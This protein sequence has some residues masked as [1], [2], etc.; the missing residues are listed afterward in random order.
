MACKFEFDASHGIV[1]CRFEGRLTDE[2]MKDYY[3]E[4]TEVYDTTPGINSALTDFSEVTSFEVSGQTILELASQEPALR[5]PQKIR[6][7][8][9]P[10]PVI[11][12]MARMFEILGERTRPNL[13]V[14]RTEREAWALLGVWEPRFGPLKK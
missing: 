3:R 12:G 5:D 7:I 6:V 9:A 8:V 1:R 11:F 4:A 13:H 2:A 10:K 14:V